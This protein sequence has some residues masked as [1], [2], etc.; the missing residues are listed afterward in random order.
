MK[1]ETQTKYE[2]SWQK[3]MRQSLLASVSEKNPIP[4]SNGPLSNSD[5]SG[6]T[7]IA[8]HLLDLQ[9]S[10]IL[11][12][13]DEIWIYIL[14]IQNLMKIRNE[15]NEKC[16]HSEEEAH[17]LLKSTNSVQKLIEHV[18]E[19]EEK[20]IKLSDTINN[21]TI[22]IV[23][24]YLLLIEKSKSII[25]N[26]ADTINQE[27]SLNL[28]PQNEGVEAVVYSATSLNDL[29]DFSINNTLAQHTNFS[30]LEYAMQKLDHT[31]YDDFIL[32]QAFILIIYRYAMTQAVVTEQKQLDVYPLLKQITA[33]KD[34]A[35]ALMDIQNLDSAFHLDAFSEQRKNSSELKN[36]L[37]INPDFIKKLEKMLMDLKIISD[38]RE[39]DD[40]DDSQTQGGS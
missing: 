20:Y 18:S 33:H 28:T 1:Q 17:N 7:K 8:K 26:L 38:S 36:S 12:V 19:Q 14:E 13:A 11:S 40:E 3:M 35:T 10:S 24:S 34:T 15:I 23:Q 16:I 9:S 31:K 37:N 39:P 29:K 27:L 4:L 30:P 25:K 2:N 32:I 6:I 5:P 22:H 21:N